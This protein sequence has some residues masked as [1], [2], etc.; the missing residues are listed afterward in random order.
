VPPSVGKLCGVVVPGDG[1]RLLADRGRLSQEELERLLAVGRALVAELDLE[2]V[3][4][5]LLDTARE[6]TGARYAALGILDESKRELERFL[7]VGVDEETR[8]MIGPLPRGHGV[9]GEADQKSRAAAA[10]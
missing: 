2:S 1:D 8:R 7:T 3:L 4:R 9:L 10:P 6:L 5:H